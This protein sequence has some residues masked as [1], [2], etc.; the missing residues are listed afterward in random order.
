MAD[1]P[2]SFLLIK[3]RCYRARSSAAGG[4]ERLSGNGRQ[5]R[6]TDLFSSSSFR[7]DKA[8]AAITSASGFLV[9]RSWRTYG[10]ER[11]KA[12]MH[13]TCS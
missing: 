2:H 11:L 9:I 10:G 6:M 3:G 1:I 7:T 12:F 13:K 5:I 8:H 4:E